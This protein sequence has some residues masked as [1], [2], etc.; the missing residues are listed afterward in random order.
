LRYPPP[1][2]SVMSKVFQVAKLILNFVTFCTL[3]VFSIFLCQPLHSA[4][5]PATPHPIVHQW[6]IPCLPLPF[7]LG[8]KINLITLMGMSLIRCVRVEACGHTSLE[9]MFDLFLL[10]GTASRS[11]SASKH[12]YHHQCISH[13]SPPLALVLSVG[14][15]PD[16]NKKT[17][18]GLFSHQG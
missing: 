7:H 18:V 17:L 1:P 13:S 8:G 4:T 11:A 6:G 3:N 16:L 14:Y 10:D 9:T 2:L 15:F 12:C 5:I